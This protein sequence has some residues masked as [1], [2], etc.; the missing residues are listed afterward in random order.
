MMY[1]VK[2]LLKESQVTQVDVCKTKYKSKHSNWG[3]GMIFTLKAWWF[4]W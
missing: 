2:D 1:Q 4:Y 3:N